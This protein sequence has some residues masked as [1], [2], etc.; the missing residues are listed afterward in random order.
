[1]FRVLET[2]TAICDRCKV[3]TTLTFPPTAD[4]V[5]MPTL[6]ILTIHRTIWHH[7]TRRHTIWLVTTK[8]LTIWLLITKRRIISRTTWRLT[9]SLRTTVEDIRVGGNTNQSIK[10]T[11]KSGLLTQTAGCM[12]A[13][14][15]LRN[16][17]RLRW[18]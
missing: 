8:L 10:A 3:R 13:V 16:P 7:T 12:P 15:I 5:G 6:A 9:T 2:S 14:F 17:P 1:M 18:A 4:S 11:T